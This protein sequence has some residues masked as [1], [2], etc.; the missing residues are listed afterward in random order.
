LILS[1]R[2]VVCASGK[3]DLEEVGCFFALPYPPFETERSK[4]I[5]DVDAGIRCGEA[6]AVELTPDVTLIFR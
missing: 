4:E 2:K 5:F 6:T 3:E 1:R